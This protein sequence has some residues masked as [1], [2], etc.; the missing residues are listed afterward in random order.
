M[1][2]LQEFLLYSPLCVFQ[3]NVYFMLSIF[4]V[5]SD[6][7]VF[8]VEEIEEI[9]DDPSDPFVADAIANERELDLS[10]EQR[11][12]YKKVVSALLMSTF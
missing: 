1:P 2:G 5:V 12:K 4:N 6:M 11:K 7:A 3:I 9:D 8:Q 10:E